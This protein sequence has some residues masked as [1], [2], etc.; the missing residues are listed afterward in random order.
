MG[1]QE[2]ENLLKEEQW[3]RT[4]VQ[5]YTVNS[6]QTLDTQIKELDEEQKTEAKNLCDKHLAER[7]R[8]SIIAMYL[9]G[10]IQLERKGADDYL[11]LLNLIEMF[12]E[13]KKWNVVEML[14]AKILSRGENKHALRLLS[15]C[16]E[17]TGKEE[18]KF[19][20]W[21]RLVKVDYE[22]IDI[23]R[24]LAIH[25]NQKGNKDKAVGFYKKAVHRLVKRKD[26]T[27]VRS[28]FASLLEL[29]G[30][31]F[32]YFMS[33]A[34][35][36]SVI[37]KST[38]IAL[39]RDLELANKDDIDRQIE[40]QKKML[41]LDREDT[42]A[43]ENLIRSYKSKYKNHSRL[44]NC[45]ESS[46]LTSNFTRDVLHSIEDFET[47]IAFDKGTFV[48]QNST[49]RIGRIRSID[50]TDVIVDFAGQN[51][52]EGARLS[53]AMAFKSLQALAK[54][55]IWV[56]KSALPREKLNKKVQEDIPWTLN[57]L[58]LSNGGKINLKEMKNELV[59]SILDAKEWTPWLNKA[60]KELMTN[61][62]FDLSNNETDTYLLRSTPVSYEEKQLSVFR[63]EKDFYDK[64]KSLKDFIASKGDVESD[65]FFEMVKYFSDMFLEE[66]GAF[67]PIV[68][69][70]DV[71]FSSFLLLEDLVKKQNMNFVNRPESL[72]F[73][74][75][76]E[77]VENVESCFA[78]IKDPELKKSFIDHVVDEIANWP[79]VL[80]QLFP[81][82]L[83]GYIPDIFRQNKKT[84]EFVKVY[85]DVAENFKEKGNT[86]LYLLKNGDPKL[87]IK[88][89]IS[90][91]Q[92]LFTKLQLLDYT[93]RCIDNKK[94]VQEN[95]KN[96]K[97]LMGL[98]FDEK[99]IFKYI[100]DGK[101]EN[102]Q[103]IYSLV[104]NVFDLPGGKKIEIKHAISEK[105]PSFRFFDE[106]VPIDKESVVPTGLFCTAASLE[107]KKK[108]LEYIQHVE[109]PEVAREI[110]TAREMGDLRENSE[111]KY[112]KE[113]QN[114]LNNTLRRL[115]E[116]IDRATVISKDKVDTTKIGFGTKVVLVDHTKGSEV[117]YTIM[118]PWE[119]NPDENIIN[120]SAP[121]GR[122][123]LNHE[124][125]ER[126][127]FVLNDQ[128]YDFTVKELTV[129]DF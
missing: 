87:W 126:F 2:I 28:L 21:E 34:D 123:L 81:F 113:K 95:R 89:G 67:K 62:L 6:F 114:L 3:T 63:G 92:L 42:F 31:N 54:S 44:K 105:Y 39:L 18:E 59:P 55:H 91:E 46:A 116:E 79:K 96:A 12:M 25:A 98:L 22:E 60:K 111:Y 107:A 66:N 78:A 74:M 83:T 16:Y 23:V 61:P 75:L 58:M 70:N 27:S 1:F 85:K 122:A 4:T 117:V 15:S 17:Q 80:S 33:V 40:C 47:N 103:K 10:S 125:G 51:S 45:L 24:H 48:F 8:N 29:D 32:G 20:L 112:G 102:A 9:S 72:T 71:T 106:V 127:T 109:L 38:S 128:P 115:A 119:S 49:N 41:L 53:T 124:I 65:F 104:A 93:N 77:R 56:L 73:A 84:T 120:L 99:D 86:L 97:T 64:I 69:A 101:E 14:C 7:E 37:S 52:K 76:F 110:G 57:T 68:V 19:A 94:E 43:R 50:E 82:Y 129:L 88:S 36:V 121:F 5:T 90:E 13:N 118:G 35:Q 30:E 11:Q 100:E 26:V 108:E